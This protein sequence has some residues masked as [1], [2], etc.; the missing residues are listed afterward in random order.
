MQ[1]LMNMENNVIY[2]EKSGPVGT[3]VLNQPEKKNAISAVMMDGLCDGIRSLDQDEEI[4]VIV[5]RGQGEDFCAGGDLDQ[6]GPRPMTAEFSRRSLRRYLAAV[7]AIRAAAKPVVALVRGY[8]VG[9]AVSLMMACDLVCAAENAKIIP[10]FCKIGLIPEM[11]LMSTLPA[12]VGPQ[13]AKEILF[14]GKRLTAAQCL[15]MG[16]IN[17]VFSEED[18]ELGAQSFVNELAALPG[19]SLQMTKGIMN[20]AADTELYS[21][22]EAESIGSPFCSQGEEFKAISAKFQKG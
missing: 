2:I 5:L 13:R 16:L 11:G 21:I 18:F 14:L 4:K 3:I 1:D 15:E 8:A 9:G 19:L 7:R 20:S 12:V 10:N 22:M 6:P 17:R